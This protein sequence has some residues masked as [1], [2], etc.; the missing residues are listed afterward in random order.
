MI[1]CITWMV[2][3]SLLVSCTP[4]V[5]AGEPEPSPAFTDA[6]EDS[7][8]TQEE[9][10]QIQ[11]DAQQQTK[12]AENQAADEQNKES[13]NDLGTVLLI[14]AAVA[15]V[16]GVV[17]WIFQRKSG[18][19]KPQVATDEIMKEYKINERMSCSSFCSAEGESD[20]PKYD[21]GLTVAYNF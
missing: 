7:T 5:M 19:Q 4:V 13:S 18:D 1:R 20:N 6:A 2:I 15:A 11:A 8:L 21:V 10:D 16:V 17:Y 12:E 9:M 14:G 3:A